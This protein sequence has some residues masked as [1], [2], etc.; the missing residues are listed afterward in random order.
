[1]DARK[2]HSS[3]I[4]LDWLSGD[5]EIPLFEPKTQHVSTKQAPDNLPSLDEALDTL[6]QELGFLD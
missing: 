6:D 2:E 4:W 1:M 5:G 3:E